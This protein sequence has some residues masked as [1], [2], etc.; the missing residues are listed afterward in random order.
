LG[1]KEAPLL[2]RLAGRHELL[3]ANCGLEFTGFAMPGAVNHNRVW[4]KSDMTNRRRA[5]RYNV[6]LPVKVELINQSPQ[7]HKTAMGRLKTRAAV[8]YASRPLLAADGD[9]SGVSL[10]TVEARTM[11]VGRFGM[12]LVLP[13]NHRGFESSAAK[14]QLKVT[15]VLPQGVVSACLET[16]YSEPLAYINSQL[17]GTRIILMSG[18]N[19]QR[20]EAFINSLRLK[21]AVRA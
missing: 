12:S 2:S 21:H 15:L 16:V 1:F 9:G 13:A 4:D 17:I 11:Q 18:D 8:H 5:P 10:V 14:R 7:T 19:T 6:K 3:C 20:Y